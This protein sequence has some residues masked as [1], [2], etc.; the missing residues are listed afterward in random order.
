MSDHAKARFHYNLAC[1]Q[2]HLGRNDA[3]LASLAAAVAGGW[4]DPDHMRKDT[5]L[6]PLREEKRFIDL[7]RQLEKG[8]A[9][10][11]N[12]ATSRSSSPASPAGGCATAS[13]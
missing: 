4:D 5:D 8:I 12:G 1:A 2:A 9:P 6:A 3:A 13:S 10:R 11:S 7:V